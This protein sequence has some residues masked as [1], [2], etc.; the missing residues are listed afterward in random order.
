VPRLKLTQHA[1]AKLKAPTPN[2]KQ[3][4]YWD[5]ELRGFGVLCSGCTTVK[6]F[7][8]QR[9]LAG[10][11]TRRVTIASVAELSLADA[12]DKA[13]PLLVSMRA[14]K[15]PKAKATG[16][17][18]QTADL[19][20]QSTRLSARSRQIYAG[21]VRNHLAELKDRPLASITPQDIDALH[22]RIAAKPGQRGV[23]SGGKTTANAAIKTFR[24][25][26]N[27]TLPRNP[28]RLRGNEWYK[29]TPRRMPIPP[30][31]LPAFYDA[32][33]QL[34]PL[35]RDYLL[36]LL[37][38]G[39]RRQEAAEL[40]WTEVD[41]EQK[42][43]R[44]PATRTKSRHALDLPMS[45]FVRALLVARRQLGDATF[46]F[47]SYGT[48]G[49]IQGGIDRIAAVKAKTGLEFS[50]HFLAAYVGARTGHGVP[51]LPG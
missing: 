19:Y 51:I 39:M 43:I 4:V 8:V 28:V 18:Q 15:D 31:R 40:R 48:T 24:L 34:T 29:T 11:K 47:P 7:I 41:F 27:D 49:H 36:L 9:D 6:S 2:G 38:T 35:A 33:L 17:L 21:L 42:L 30:E 3:T 46:V 14:G 16:T 37:F 23:A 26:Y 32:C 13:R 10:G 25:L 20:L 12:K 22:N 44:L 1:I 50:L 5:A 45:D